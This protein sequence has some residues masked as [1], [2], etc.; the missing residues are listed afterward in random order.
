MYESCHAY[1]WLSPVWHICMSDFTRMKIHVIH[2]KTTRLLPWR[3]EWLVQ[4]CDM[5]HSYVWRDSVM[6]ATWLIHMCDV[7]HSCVYHHSFRRLTWHIHVC[8]TTPSNAFTCVAWQRHVL[9]IA[10]VNESC[11]TYEW[12]TSHIWMS[13][14]AH[15]TESCHTYKWVMSHIWTSH[16]TQLPPLTLAVEEDKMSTVPTVS[17]TSSMI[18]VQ[19]EGKSEER[20]KH[21][22]QMQDFPP[23][24]PNSPTCAATVQVDSRSSVASPLPSQ[25]HTAVTPA[26]REGT[27]LQCTVAAYCCSVLLQ[28]IY[29]AVSSRSHGTKSTSVV[30]MMPRWYPCTAKT[31][32]MPY[33]GAP[34]RPRAMRVVQMR[35]GEKMWGL[36]WRVYWVYQYYPGVYSWLIWGLPILDLRVYAHGKRIISSLVSVDKPPGIV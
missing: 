3:Y 8:T 28:W 35:D 4:M 20:K 16:V 6:C 22:F 29:W 15:M 26:I 21:V 33:L 27:L 5:T 30:G 31:H 32:R 10:R 19:G 1:V 34:K 9:Y 14:V 24:T 13:H 11:H 7:T 12:V 17:R 25:T 2:L 23:N 18:G 36:C